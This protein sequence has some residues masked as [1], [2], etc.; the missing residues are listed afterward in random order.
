MVKASQL[1]SGGG[2][3]GPEAE[4]SIL[5][6]DINIDALKVLMKL[7]LKKYGNGTETSSDDFRELVNQV[8]L[9]KKKERNTV[10]SDSNEMIVH[11]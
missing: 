3:W 8:F 11:W 10:P 7:F 4:G 1:L 2:Y 5:P 9:N 6:E